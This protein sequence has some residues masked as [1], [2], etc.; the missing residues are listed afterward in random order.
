[1]SLK[2]IDREERYFLIFTAQTQG[3]SEI[4]FKNVE[5]V[6]PMILESGLKH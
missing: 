2:I 5:M 4:L 3:Q 6:P 1:M